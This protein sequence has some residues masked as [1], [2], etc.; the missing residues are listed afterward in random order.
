MSGVIS[1]KT[2]LEALP[3]VTDVE[4]ELARI[5]DEQGV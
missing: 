4:D 5:D 3:I 1:R 2:L